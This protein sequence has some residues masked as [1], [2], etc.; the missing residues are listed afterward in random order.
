MRLSTRLLPRL[1][2]LMIGAFGA[3]S[4]IGCGGEHDATEKQLAELHG[5][6][7]RLR[8][9]QSTLAERLDA[10]DIER[11]AFARRAST[12]STA[13]AT[14][15]PIALPSATAPAARASDRA[16]DRDRPELEVVHLSPSE[17]DGDVDSEAPRPM[18]RANGEAA[19]ARQ[20]LS[21]KTISSRSATRRGV[22]PSTPK[23]A[24][25]A[26]ARP[27]TKP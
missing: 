11:G 9:T 4:A 19:G 25:D 22:V 13:M 7:A 12:P 18:I 8:A 27:V 21:N 10:I 24:A 3:F 17:G 5:E 2:S 14:A 6:I 16:S 20:T 15:A 1:A 23:K 26:D